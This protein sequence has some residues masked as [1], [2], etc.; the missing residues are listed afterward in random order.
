MIVYLE[1]RMERLNSEESKI[2][3]RTMLCDLNIDIEKWKSSMARGIRNKKRFQSC[4]DS[5]GE[6]LHLQALQG[7]SGRNHVDPSFQDNVLNPDGFFKYIYH[8]R[9][10]INLHS[11]INSGLISGGQILSNRQTVFFLLVEPMDKKHKS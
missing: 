7:H 9:C 1:K 3:F 8:V 5:S 2:I 6:I 10:A 4:T 11:I